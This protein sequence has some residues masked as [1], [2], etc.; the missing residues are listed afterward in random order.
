MPTIAL[1]D[2]LIN[3]RQ[4]AY[5]MRHFYLGAEHLFIA[6]LDIKGSIA[7]SILQEQGLKPEYVIDAIRRKVGKGSK[8]RL[9]AG[10]PNTPRAE[11][12]LGIAND[13]ALENGREEINE[14]D[15]LIALLEEEDSIPIR[16]LKALSLPDMQIL[17]EIARTYTLNRDSQRPY[18]KVDF[19][20]EFERAETLSK[21][22]LFI[23]RRMFYGYAQI[24]VERQLTGG[25][26]KAT[27][28]AVT[29]IDG[30]NR[31]HATVVVK[32]DDHDTIL[33]EAQ[34][35]ESYVKGL[36]P[37]LTARL[38]DKPVAPETSDMAAIKYTLVSGYDQIPH[39]LRAIVKEWDAQK[40]G[41]WIK[42]ELYPAFGRIW[43]QQNRPFRFQV[44]REYDWLL[45]PVLTLEY[46]KDKALP[47]NGHVLKFP[48]KRARLHE[49]EYGDMVSVENFTVQRVY[50]ERSAIQLAISQGTESIAAYKIEVRGVDLSKDTFYRGE[51]VDS[52]VGRVYKTRNEQL[53]H[54]MR[55]LSP[56]FDTAGEKIASGNDLIEK[57]PNPIIAYEEMLDRYVNGSLSTIHGD[58]HLGNI[59][60]GPNNSAFLIDFAHT[61]DGHTAFDWA[62]LEVSLLSEVVMPA[63][64]ESWDDARTVLRYLIPFN[65]KQPLP[66]THPKIATAL[67]TIQYVRDIAQECLASHDSWAEYFTALA[68]CS[69]RALTWGTMPIASRRL[70]FYVAALSMHEL[71]T[72]FRPTSETDTPSPEETDITGRSTLL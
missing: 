46:T 14:R 5:R 19:G 15:L 66:N 7:G 64:G 49:L 60:I 13:L 22:H 58:L 16:V 51:V 47:N 4:E 39:D 42:N 18:V 36:L 38:E 65:G 8:N 9:W 40:L 54:A 12:L 68:L 71:R 55:A 26:T 45:P 57:L 2:I 33:D 20:P 30:D 44:W 41:Q 17:A 69:L 28:L 25:Y 10:I 31:P 1:K 59:M 27:L 53:I 62:T 67:E 50:P 11:V 52:I 61:R 34:R 24:R 63:A 72:R 3:A 43:W 21:D 29:P 70:M 56:D 6:M 48:V 23:L 32:I 35:Y 37:A